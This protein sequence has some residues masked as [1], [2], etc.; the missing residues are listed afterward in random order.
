M[1]EKLRIKSRGS[2]RFSVSVTSSDRWS[3]FTRQKL[4]GVLAPLIHRRKKP[5]MAIQH[6]HSTVALYSMSGILSGGKIGPFCVR[7]G[8]GFFEISRGFPEPFRQEATGVVSQVDQQTI[9]TGI[10]TGRADCCYESPSFSPKRLSQRPRTG[11]GV[12]SNVV[13]SVSLFDRC[14]LRLA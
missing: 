9:A 6:S 7:P 4:R 10:R 8:S 5:T 13:S 12:A 14:S 3:R 11:L 2:C 1:R